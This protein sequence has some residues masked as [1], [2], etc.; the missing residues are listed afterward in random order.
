MEFRFWIAGAHSVD[1]AARLLRLFFFSSFA[2]S[3]VHRARESYSHRSD[4]TI[5][6]KGSSFGHSGHFVSST[7]F[8]TTN[9]NLHDTGT[10]LQTTIV[11]GT[12]LTAVIPEQLLQSPTSV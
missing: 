7:V 2:I 3:Y 12:Q 10:W 11:S 9:G 5:T 4:L 6:I 1:V 8:W